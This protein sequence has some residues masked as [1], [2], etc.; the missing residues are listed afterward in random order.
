[1]DRE[2]PEPIARVK[3]ESQPMY[4]AMRAMMEAI[5]SWRAIASPQ[6]RER[7]EGKCRFTK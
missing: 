4:E 7:K 6:I 5:D 2:A 1:M 3:A